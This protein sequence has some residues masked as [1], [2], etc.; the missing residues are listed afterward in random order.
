MDQKRP[1]TPSNRNFTLHQLVLGRVRMACTRQK[2]IQTR[3]SRVVRVER[4]TRK[5]FHNN[6]PG[7]ND[8]LRRRR[9]PRIDPEQSGAGHEGGRRRGKINFNFCWLGR[10]FYFTNFCFFTL[11]FVLRCG[12][13]MLTNRGRTRQMNLNFVQIFYFT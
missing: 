5:K 13:E 9:L 8:A 6:F 3:P 11:A 2:P 10:H 7:Q 1:Y 12:A 4:Y